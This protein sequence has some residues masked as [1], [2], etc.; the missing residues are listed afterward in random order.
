MSTAEESRNGSEE[1]RDNHKEGPDHK[2]LNILIGTPE[3]VLDFREYLAGSR[4]IGDGWLFEA[5]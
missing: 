1:I 3:K 4:R 2:K 5:R